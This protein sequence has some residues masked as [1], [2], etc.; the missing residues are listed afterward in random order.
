MLRYKP[1]GQRTEPL[2]VW[3]GDVLGWGCSVGYPQH[4]SRKEAT[5]FDPFGSQEVKFAQ[6]CVIKH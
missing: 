3:E 6:S 1:V 4:V 2:R 5:Q